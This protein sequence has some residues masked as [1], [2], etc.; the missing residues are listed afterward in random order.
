MDQS[1]DESWRCTA[2]KNKISTERCI[3]RKKTGLEFCGIHSKTPNIRLWS[4]IFDMSSS[5]ILKVAKIQAIWKGRFIRKINNL[6]GIGL[7]KRS[8]CM[9]DSELITGEEKERFHP[10]S[11]FSIKDNGKIY[12]FDIESLFAWTF[13]KLS[14]TN[15]YTR[16]ELS[17]DD[18][19]RMRTLI[20]ILKKFQNKRIL[21]NRL[22][23]I[24]FSERSFNL[25]IDITRRFRE[26]GFTKFSPGWF[27]ELTPSDRNIF[28]RNIIVSLNNISITD[29]KIM[30]SDFGDEFLISVF[31]RHK[32]YQ[33]DYEQSNFRLSEIMMKL[34]DNTS[35]ESEEYFLMLLIIQSL[36]SVS[37]ECYAEYF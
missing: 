27:M 33:M 1:I 17:N 32:W 19:K 22:A 25:S 30:V 10:D 3:R 37:Q 15:P 20:F 18:M 12:W 7:F 6:K 13:G 36:G 16:N 14:P 31:G 23:N 26:S 28:C 4:K 2:C 21:F 11:Y 29:K 9:N 35:C 24:P 5:D 34:L 8:I